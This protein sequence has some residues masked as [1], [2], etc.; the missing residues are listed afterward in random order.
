MISFQLT[1]GKR[2]KSQEPF[3]GLINLVSRE[4]RMYSWE[5]GFCVSECGGYIQLFKYTY[6]IF[7]IDLRGSLLTS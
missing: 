7:T 2:L 1:P 3:V 5:P 6:S 4:V